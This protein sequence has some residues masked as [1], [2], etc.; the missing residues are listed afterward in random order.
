MSASNNAKS[1][2]SEVVRKLYF[3]FS[4]DGDDAA[5]AWRTND[6]AVLQFVSS[7][8]P[9]LERDMPTHKVSAILALAVKGCT[10]A[11]VGGRPRQTMAAYVDAVGRVMRHVGDL[12]EDCTPEDITAIVET[13]PCAVS[14]VV[15]TTAAVLMRPTRRYWEVISASRVSKN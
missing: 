3:D 5:C 4:N 1:G 8:R 2:L 7:L 15:M 9:V 13:L 12:P 11:D 14:R 10:V 6:D